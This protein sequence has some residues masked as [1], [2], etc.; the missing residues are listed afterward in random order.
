MD[1]TTFYVVVSQPN[2]SCYSYT[3]VKVNAHNDPVI[4]SITISDG[5]TNICEGG[6]FTLV[7][8]AS[9][10]DN[11]G[12]PTYTWF[13]NGVEILNATDSVI[14]ESP[15][16]VDGDL[17]NYTYQVI[18]TLTASGCQSVIDTN[19]TMDVHV[20][21]NSTVQ[22]EG[23]PI[24]CGAGLNRAVAHLTAHLNDTVADVDGY[25]YEWRLFN[26]TIN[27]T[28][29]SLIN[30]VADTMVLDYGLAVSDNPYI[31]KVIVHNPNG[32]SNESADFYVYVNDTASIVV[33]V[34]ESDICEGGQVTF[35]ANI[36]DYNMPNLTYQ[37]FV[38]DTN[39]ANVIGGATLPTYTTTLDTVKT[40][41]YFVKVYQPTSG[42]VAYG[43]DTV[44]VHA[45]PTVALAISDETPDTNIC[46]G[47]Q[48]TL[49]ATATYDPELGEP[50]FTWFRNGV[51]VV[52]ATDSV[53]TDSPLAVDG[54]VTNYRYEVI[55]TLA[56]S[57]CQSVVDTASTINVHVYGNP[58]VEIA[59]DHNICGAGEG[60]DTCKLIAN[61]ND[62]LRMLTVTL[63]NG[64]CSPEQSTA[65]IADSL[66][67][68]MVLNST[69]YSHPTTSRTSSL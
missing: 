35:T 62:T 61:V 3:S 51:R 54:D 40:Y 69:W 14:T 36:G 34:N 45:D 5:D 50:V 66:A 65:R 47:G 63:T 27:A 20:Y 67:A 21:P 15:V 43:S 59:G 10:D 60:L 64:D 33:T 38:G 49:T 52:N 11:L 55:V 1:T 30:R 48:I 56:Q 68:P 23:D 32:C 57:G 44:K 13:R 39:A 2:S 28:D 42:C 9:F 17:T 58:V 31:F 37:W 25:T 24:I 46:E 4:D 16:T 29:D 26:R 12:T 18:V 8:H 19:S 41:T 6:Q 7:A 53:L 22:I